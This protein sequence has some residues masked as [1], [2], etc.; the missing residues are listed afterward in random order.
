MLSPESWATGLMAA[1]LS[2][3]LTV[4]LGITVCQSTHICLGLEG[5]LAP[6]LGWLV[7]LEAILGQDRQVQG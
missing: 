3:R 7:G 6:L 2:V 1:G 4:W 5:H